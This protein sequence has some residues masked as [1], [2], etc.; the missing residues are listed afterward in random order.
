MRDNTNELL[1][2]ANERLS[3]ANLGL[4][5]EREGNALY[6]RGVLPPKQGSLRDKPYQQRIALSRL[7][8]RANPFGIKEAENEALKIGGLLARGQF[9]WEPYGKTSSKPT[10][11]SEWV[12]RYEVDYFNKR[13]RTP[14]SETTWDSDY[15]QVFK[16]LPANAALTV[17]L[18]NTE[19]LKTKP[20][21]RTRRR[22]V[23]ALSLLGKFAGLNCDYAHLKGNYSQRKVNPREIPTDDDIALW[24]TK[25]KNPAWRWA[26]G[27]LSTYGIRPSEI[28]SLDFSHFPILKVLDGKT[29][30]RQVWPLYPEWA[31]QWDLDNIYL[32]ECSG[33][34]NRDLGQRVGQAFRRANLPFPAYALRHAWAIRSMRLRVDQAL[35]A[36]Q[37]GHALAVH[38]DIYHLH[39]Q[40]QFYSET[41]LDF[42]SQGNRP[43]PPLNKS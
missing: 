6:L 30:S 21:T 1:F 34:T 23:Q 27:I 15:A 35:A 9:T 43:P 19:I 4:K 32:P 11:A 41:Y 14:K 20:D 8:I 26:Y 18:L 25:I 10:T 31:D 16:K 39:I 37:M 5:I 29:G 24:L 12:A 3:K 7:N 22:T 13:A 33:K 36:K 28:F 38:T 40:E 2:K 17:D 42:L